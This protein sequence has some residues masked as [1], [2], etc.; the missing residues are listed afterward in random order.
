MKKLLLTI[1]LIPIVG[2]SQTINGISIVDLEA[3]YIEIVGTVK[4]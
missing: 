1:I 2:F 4:Y 3:K